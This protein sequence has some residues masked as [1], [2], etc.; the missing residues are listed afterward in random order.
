MLR[1]SP[2]R[3]GMRDMADATSVSYIDKLR[4][5]GDQQEA[6]RASVSL[7]SAL[8]LRDAGPTDTIPARN[9]FIALEESLDQ[10][11]RDLEL[12]S[13]QYDLLSTDHLRSGDK[14]AAATALLHKA[15]SFQDWRCREALEKLSSHFDNSSDSAIQSTVLDGLFEHLSICPKDDPGL[16]PVLKRYVALATR[17]G[18]AADETGDVILV[19]EEKLEGTIVA[20]WVDIA[21]AFL[22][23]HGES[24]DAELRAKLSERV[25]SRLLVLRR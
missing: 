10:D 3:G 21:Q 17:T 1:L 8:A 16:L 24:L 11:E 18:Q 20:G 6:R 4:Q 14:A 7:L 13:A 19:S 25:A 23:G 5:A 15:Y 2:L 22:A 12:L 9:Q